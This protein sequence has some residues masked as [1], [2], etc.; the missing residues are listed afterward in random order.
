[1]GKIAM[2]TRHGTYALVLKCRETRQVR[3]GRPGSLNLWR[4]F[5]VYIGSAFGA[6]G[7]AARIRHHQEVA[8]RPHWH[9]DYLGA[10]SDLV[11]VW[12]TTDPGRAEHAW[13]NAAARLPGAGVPMPGFGSSDCKCATHL[14]WFAEM[15]SVSAFRKHIDAPVM[16]LVV[17]GANPCGVEVGGTCC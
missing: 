3:I 8:H 10:M 12:F 7:L 1:M 16:R 13:A 11:E 17:S 5:Y 4:G 6:G 9:I 15:P 14:F 2:T